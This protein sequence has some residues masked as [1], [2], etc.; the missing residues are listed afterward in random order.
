MIFRV[1]PE[2]QRHELELMI[3]VDAFQLRVFYDHLPFETKC[4]TRVLHA[5][6][7]SPL[8]GMLCGK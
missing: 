4:L 3:L 8:F 7:G 6:I 2:M 1:V 5:L